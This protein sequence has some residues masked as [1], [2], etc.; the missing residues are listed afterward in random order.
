LF[1]AWLPEP[2][3]CGDSGRAIFPDFFAVA[4]LPFLVALLDGVLFAVLTGA[5][6]FVAA[7]PGFFAVALLPLLLDVFFFGVLTSTVLFAAALMGFRTVVLLLALAGLRSRFTVDFGI[8][9]LRHPV[10]G[11]RKPSD[12]HL[13]IRQSGISCSKR[14]VQAAILAM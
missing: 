1:L 14:I 5:I 13:M 3:G 2:P 9:A 7:L 11:C 10:R 8:L 6:F 12:H 4:F